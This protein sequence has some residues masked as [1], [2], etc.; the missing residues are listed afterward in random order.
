MHIAY[1]PCKVMEP[2]ILKHFSPKSKVMFRY[3]SEH[4]RNSTN[5]DMD[6]Y[7]HVL[8]EYT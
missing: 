2:Y 3:S 6:I 8:L 5:E 4:L 1:M 7:K